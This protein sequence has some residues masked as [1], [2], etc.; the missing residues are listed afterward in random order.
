MNPIPH[1]FT[2]PTRLPTDWHQRL[3][4]WFKT[5]LALASKT[6]AKELPVALETSFKDVDLCFAH[7]ALARLSDG[8]LAY[9]VKL[10]QDR[11]PTF[12]TM[13]KALLLNLV[14]ALL[15]EKA[16]DTAERELTPVE[17][18]RTALV[19][20]LARLVEY[21]SAE[22]QAFNRSGF[23]AQGITFGFEFRY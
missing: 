7:Q 6:W 14:G 21:R 20:G 23:R 16:T 15:G 11:V 12:F 9:R 17:K 5:A 2:K 10:A 3:T 8:F 19:F 22:S 4:A 1:D 18:A 13:P